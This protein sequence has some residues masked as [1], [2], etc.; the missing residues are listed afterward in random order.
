MLV[1]W[2][3]PSEHD[4]HAARIVVPVTLLAIGTSFAGFLLATLMYG[5]G[6]LSAEDVRRQFAPLYVFLR[7][8]WWFDELYARLFVR[9]AL[10]I[11]GV[12]AF[13]DR[14]WIDGFIHLVARVTRGLSVAWDRLVDQSIIDG[15]VNLAAGWTYA[16]GRSLRGVQTGHIRQYVMFIVIAAVALFVLI[17][18]WNSTLA[19]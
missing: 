19:G 17:S 11:A 6:K 13:I 12:A 16:F 18:F 1:N 5:L 9:P 7:N 15:A 14:R 8:K 2:T 4:A 3:W 10:A